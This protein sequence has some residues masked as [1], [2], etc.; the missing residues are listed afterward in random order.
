LN[1]SYRREGDKGHNARCCE[2]LRIKDYEHDNADARSWP[3]RT[4][5]YFDSEAKH[6]Q[7]RGGGSAPGNDQ[8]VLYKRPYGPGGRRR[9][10][11]HHRAKGRDLLLALSLKLLLSE[12]A[13]IETEMMI[14]EYLLLRDQ[15]MGCAA[16]TSRAESEK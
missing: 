3:L 12:T 1:S 4:G 10:H 9:A 16:K 14:D 5:S 6:R 15:L 8:A 13:P 2:Q 11:R 7:A